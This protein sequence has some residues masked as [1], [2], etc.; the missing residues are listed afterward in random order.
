MKQWLNVKVL[1]FRPLQYDSMMGIVAILILYDGLRNDHYRFGKAFCL[2]KNR[3]GTRIFFKVTGLT[4][5]KPDLTSFSIM[6]PV[7]G[8]GDAFKTI[9]GCGLLLFFSLVSCTTLG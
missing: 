1:W 3:G 6:F 4:K 9:P 2:I 7:G 5:S 8:L